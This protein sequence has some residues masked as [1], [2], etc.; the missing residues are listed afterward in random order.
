MHFAEITNKFMSTRKTPNFTMSFTKWNK[1]SP[2]TLAMNSSAS[3][4]EVFTFYFPTP[5]INMNSGKDIPEN[6]LDVNFSMI[7]SRP[8]KL[9]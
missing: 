9:H 5:S 2:F 3:T 8:L 7:V 4:A 1:I 6:A